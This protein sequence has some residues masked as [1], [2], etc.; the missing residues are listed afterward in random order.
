M[1]N[2]VH[3][4]GYLAALDLPGRVE[5]VLEGV[6]VEVDVSVFLVDHLEIADVIF[7]SDKVTINILSTCH[8]LLGCLKW[9]NPCI[10]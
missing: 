7:W 4:L 10:A 1:F 3:S 9:K 8:R 2:G 5:L 6:A